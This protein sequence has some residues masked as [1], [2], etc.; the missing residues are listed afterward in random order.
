MNSH[1][2]KVKSTNFRD[3]NAEMVNLILDQLGVEIPELA[4]H[5][6]IE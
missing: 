2:I 1:L 3:A 4:R 6:G 5:V